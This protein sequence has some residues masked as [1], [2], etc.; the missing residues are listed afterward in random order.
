MA[1]EK[2]MSSEYKNWNRLFQLIDHGGKNICYNVLFKKEKW[3][4]DG[5]KLYQK[6][7]PHLS[8]ICKFK[9]QRKILGPSNR[10]TDYKKFDLTLFTRIIEVMFG[11]KY[12]LLV[13]DL[14]DARNKECHRGDKTLSNPD[15]NQLWKRAEDMLQKHGFDVTSVK[16]L[17]TCDSSLD[18]QLKDIAI[19]K[20][21]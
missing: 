19:V 18:Q 3:P 16:D 1:T 5:K 11:S 9:K 8:K 21:R 15:F 20:G 13:K 14:R 12:K 2:D 10:S 4:T 6:L 7:Q 17:R